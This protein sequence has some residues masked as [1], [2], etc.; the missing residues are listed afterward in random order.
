MSECGALYMG[1]AAPVS[2]RVELPYDVYR[3][4]VGLAVVHTGGDVS[5]M[6]AKLAVMA[7]LGPAAM[8]MCAGGEDD[9]QE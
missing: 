1:A 4:I 6:I 8:A 9:D 3:H 7:A 5:R 2:V